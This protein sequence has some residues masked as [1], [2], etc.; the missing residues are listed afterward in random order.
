MIY[1]K[2]VITTVG[3]ATGAQVTYTVPAGKTLV[4][5]DMRSKWISGTLATISVNIFGLAFIEEMNTQSGQHFAQWQGMQALNAG[6]VLQC[7]MTAGSASL[8]VTGY[9][10]NLV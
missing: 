2:R 10:L 9:V 7:S 4:I 8:I 5:K 6:E 3:M 1:T